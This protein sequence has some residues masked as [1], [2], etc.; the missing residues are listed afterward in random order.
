MWLK[1]CKSFFHLEDDIFIAFVYVA[2]LSSILA[3]KNT[4][5]FEVLEH[6]LATYAREGNCILFGDFNAN[7]S[8][9]PDYCVHNVSI[10]SD[11]HDH[12]TSIADHHSLV[13]RNNL[14][15]HG[16]DAYGRKLLELL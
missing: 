4:D 10:N 1:L 13:N 15:G 16:V 9:D 7:T 6:D 11:I 3:K 5:I 2:S 12:V 14:D 8:S